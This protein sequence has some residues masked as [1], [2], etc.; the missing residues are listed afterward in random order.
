MYSFWGFL[1]IDMWLDIV[2]MYEKN[3]KTENKNAQ[4]FFRFFERFSC[5]Y[6]FTKKKSKN[7]KYLFLNFSEKSA[8]LIENSS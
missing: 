5:A 3:M 6:F 7:T 8:L 1:Y 2:L 4:N